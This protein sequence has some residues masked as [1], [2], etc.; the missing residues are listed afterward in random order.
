MSSTVLSLSMWILGTSLA[1]ISG[2][3]TARSARDFYA[4]LQKPTWAPPAWLFGP[5]WTVLYIVMAVAAW[6]IWN[7]YGFDGARGELVIYGIQ[8]AL[9]AAWSWFFFVKRSG[10]AATI[11]VSLLLTA[12]I[13]TM[14]AFWRRDAVAGA[15]FIPYVTWVS[16]A[17][18]L[19][20]SVSSRNPRLL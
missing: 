16:F 20:V 1:A 7:T 5:A 10:R 4:T 17:T 19:T 9:N 13:A 12:V 2:A 11:E 14:V 6:R 15:L 3:V 18:A 8:L